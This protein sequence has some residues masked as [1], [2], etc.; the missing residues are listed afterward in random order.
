MDPNTPVP[1]SDPSGAPVGNPN[2][3]APPVVDPPAGVVTDPPAGSPTPEPAKTFSQEQL[4]AIIGD[5]LAR[6]R[7][8]YKDH[9]QLAADAKAWKEYQDSQKDE[10]TRIKEQ[11]DADKAELSQLR[12][13]QIRNEVLK[14]T[15]LP[16]AFA[17]RLSGE[18]REELFADAVELMKIL[19]QPQE[20]AQP[21]P[22]A[23][24]SR[25]IPQGWGGG[26]PGGE[27]PFDINSVLAQ[28]PRD[29]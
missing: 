4:E 23:P 16:E 8:K 28:I 13:A 7:E 2:P 15:G 5:R 22:P 18:T 14:E 20:P 26:A 21:A 10:V 27:E 9:D 24:G 3:E 12:K 29:R 17:G 19:P 25:P 6:E 11:W 1:N